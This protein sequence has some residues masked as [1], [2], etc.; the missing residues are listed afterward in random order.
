METIL[1]FTGV[2]IG[3]LAVVFLFV[4]CAFWL[5]ANGIDSRYKDIDSSFREYSPDEISSIKNNIIEKRKQKRERHAKGK[6]N[7]QDSNSV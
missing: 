4:F 6:S 7:V 2:I 5:I 3:V 1:I